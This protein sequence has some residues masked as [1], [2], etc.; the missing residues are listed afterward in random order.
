MVTIGMNYKVLP[1]KEKVLEDA[2]KSVLKVMSE[3][4][5]HRK[6]FLFRDT[7][8]GRNYLIMSDWSSEEAFNTF[9]KSDRFKKV[10]DW[11]KEQVLEARPE[12]K[13]YN[14]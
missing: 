1:G 6:S 13:V 2:F 14:H 9:I 11:G 8:D 3:L 5:G 7:N 10:T 12:H 4:E